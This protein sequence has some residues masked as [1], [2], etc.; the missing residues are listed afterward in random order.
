MRSLEKGFN[1]IPGHAQAVGNVTLKS[2]QL[3]PR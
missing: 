2:R 1:E 3:A